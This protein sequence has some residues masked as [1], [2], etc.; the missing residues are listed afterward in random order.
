MGRPKKV[1][2][3]P[4]EEVKNTAEEAVPVP[5][6]ASETPEAVKPEEPKEAAPEIAPEVVPAEP[7]P[8]VS[9]KYASEVNPES[10][11]ESQF[12]YIKEEEGEC[13]V[14]QKDGLYIRTYSKRIHG[15]RYRELAQEFIVK[16]SMKLSGFILAV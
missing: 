11:K 13:H 8:S 2:V 3:A 4:A 10:K 9:V 16:H 14:H 15:D 5:E 1:V 12:Y 6:V 7:V